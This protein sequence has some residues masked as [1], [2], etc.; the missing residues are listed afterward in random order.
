MAEEDEIKAARVQALCERRAEIAV[1]MNELCLELAK[2]DLE[3]MRTGG[4]I[5]GAI[6][7]TI[8]GTIGVRSTPL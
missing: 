5:G 7:G 6:G 8:G 3:L 1:R 2:V 4:I